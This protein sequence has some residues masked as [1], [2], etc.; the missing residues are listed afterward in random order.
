[1]INVDEMYRQMIEQIEDY[2]IFLLDENGMIKT[3]NKGAQ[4]IKGYTEEE[5]LGKSFRW[6]YTPEDRAKKLPEA[7]LEIAMRN[8][9][10]L[11]EGW[12]VRKDGTQIW[13]SVHLTAI[14]DEDNRVI[15]FTKI[16]RDLTDKK[17]AQEAERAANR[18][19]D[20]FFKIFNASPSGMAI[21]SIESGKFLEI[22]QSFEDAFGYSRE[23]AIGLSADE[24]GIASNDT[25]AK[26]F[27]KLQKQGFLR[28]EEVPCVRRDGKRVDTIFS[29][30]LFELNGKP[31]FLSIFHDITPMKELEREIIRSESK[32]RTI[33]EEAGDVLYTTDIYG[34]FTFL[35][36]RIA[37]LAGYSGEELVGKNFSVL[38]APEWNEKVNQNYHN[39]YR[40]NIPET[41]M[42]F[43]IFT[44]SGE[45]KWIEQ[46]AILQKER[47]RITGFQCVVHDI[48]ERK[49]ADLLMAEQKKI[50]EL[51]NKDMLGSINYAKRI[52]EAIFPPEELVTEL[53][54]NSFILYKPKDIVSGDFYWVEKFKDKVYIAA[55]DCTGHGVPGALMSIIG[56]NLLSKSIN[57]HNRIRPS[58]ILDEL[59]NGI[60]VTFRNEL[61]KSGVKDTMDISICSI[62]LK[63]KWMEFAG[64][65]NSV[66]LFRKNQFTRMPADRFPIGIRSGGELKR[67]TNNQLKLEKG[68]TI[69]LFSDGYPD[70][71][72]GPNGKKLKISGFKEILVK[73]QHEP[74][75][76]QKKLL[77]KA[78][79]DWRRGEEQTDD[80]LVMGIR[81]Q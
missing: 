80:I 26:S 55:V 70:Q 71:F 54:P 15:G 9:K 27:G 13:A 48:T 29:V 39:Q 56:Y 11:D 12:R 41:V 42:E 25:Q 74:I 35:N 8:G 31:C 28:N 4:K 57:E 32:Y 51:K 62:D 73:I 45:P 24:L 22:N 47:N 10:S 20:N 44:K 2:A 40:N 79:E 61:G 16:T 67:F 66:Y 6:F 68:D 65:Y 7:L 30:E 1:M 81:I 64:A 37:A 60:N 53:I 43:I 49:Q 50:I 17:M 3:W 69:Y 72:G 34:N 18:A 5:I 76:N 38:V 36:K 63:T 21:V 75:Q 58:E 23:E 52:Q 59:S 46:V 33:I 19:Q 14:H 77:D 78:L